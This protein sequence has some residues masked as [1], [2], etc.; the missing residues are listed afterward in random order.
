M[1]QGTLNLPCQH[2]CQASSGSLSSSSAPSSPY[3]GSL[4]ARHHAVDTAGLKGQI[5]LR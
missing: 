2:T 5:V 1:P 3:K 4:N